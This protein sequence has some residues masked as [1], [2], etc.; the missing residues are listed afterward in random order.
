MFYAV[1]KAV[2]GERSKINVLLEAKDE[3][4]S[5]LV[6]I[7]YNKQTE[8]TLE[9]EDVSVLEWVEKLFKE[10]IVMNGF[11]SLVYNNVPLDNEDF[12]LNCDEFTQIGIQ[13]CIKLCM[14]FPGKLNF[15]FIWVI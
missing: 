4:I 7:L 12:K 2:R 9:E 5:S 15:L 1:L 3:R 6:E 8:M 14:N 10:T 13:K 11:D